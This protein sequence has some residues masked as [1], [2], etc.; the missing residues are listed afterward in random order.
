MYIKAGLGPAWIAIHFDSLLIRDDSQMSES[1]FTFLWF[2]IRFF[3]SV[4]LKTRYDL[5]NKGTGCHKGPERACTQQKW[6]MQL[7]ACIQKGER[8]HK[9]VGN[10]LWRACI[11][12][13]ARF[14]FIVG[15]VFLERIADRIRPT[16]NSCKLIFDLQGNHDSRRIKSNQNQIESKWIKLNWIANQK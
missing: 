9:W 13:Y 6:L 2:K 16:A 7:N 4:Y 15:V 12:I 3:F 10:L 1:R 8:I 11:L 14:I 5:I